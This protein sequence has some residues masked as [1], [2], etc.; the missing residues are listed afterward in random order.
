MRKLLACALVAHHG[1]LHD[2]TSLPLLTCPRV[3]LFRRTIFSKAHTPLT[4]YDFFMFRLRTHFPPFNEY[5]SNN[6]GLVH[7][8][9]VGHV[10][11]AD[12]RCTVSDKRQTS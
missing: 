11:N 4:K 1:I 6:A 10:V 12:I 8:R 7:D 5:R 9:D 3:G 2:F